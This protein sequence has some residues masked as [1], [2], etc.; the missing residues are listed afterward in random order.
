MS[1]SSGLITYND[2]LQYQI[3]RR[4]NQNYELDPLSFDV[5]LNGGIGIHLIVL[6]LWTVL[7]Q[8]AL[9]GV[10]HFQSRSV[11]P[12][13]KSDRGVSAAFKNKVYPPGGEEDRDV[14]AERIK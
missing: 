13:N 4:Y 3:L 7:A 12:S 11:G 10:L 8:I 6:L 1:G 9:H 14:A 5:E 2:L